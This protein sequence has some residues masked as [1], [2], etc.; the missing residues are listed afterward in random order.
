MPAG[1]EPA[2]DRIAQSICYLIFCYSTNEPAIWRNVL[3]WI[4][5]GPHQDE[6]NVMTAVVARRKR[7]AINAGYL[8]FDCVVLVVND[9]INSR[10]GYF[11]AGPEGASGVGH[12]ASALGSLRGGYN[13]KRR[14]A[15][16]PPAQHLCPTICLTIAV[17]RMRTSLCANEIKNG[18]SRRYCFCLLSQALSERA[19]NQA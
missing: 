13:I 7:L 9:S 8:T 19:K 17:L 4:N 18:P 6:S 2:S 10:M 12:C 1:R 14:R 11:L 15:M 3:C 5:V 16:R